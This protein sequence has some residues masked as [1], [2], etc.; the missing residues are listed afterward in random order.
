METRILKDRS[1]K[2]RKSHTCY[3]SGAEIHPGEIYR[4]IVQVWEGELQSFAIKRRCR[5]Q[6]YIDR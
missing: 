2:A 5:S 6:D 3:F 1:V 4:R